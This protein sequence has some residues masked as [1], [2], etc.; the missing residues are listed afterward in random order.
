MPDVPDAADGGSSLERLLGSIMHGG[1]PQILAGP[2]GKALSQLIGAAVAV[3]ATWLES[4]VLVAK[5]TNKARAEMMRAL[6]KEA[7]RRAVKD[8]ALVARTLDTLMPARWPN[9]KPAKTLRSGPSLSCRI[10]RPRRMVHRRIL[11]G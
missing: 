5:E 7:T 3:P 4:R 9:R 2:A 10:N 1:L 11:T 8:E 6:A